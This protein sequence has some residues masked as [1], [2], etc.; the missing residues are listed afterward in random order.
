MMY[1]ITDNE[2]NKLS[3]SSKT[4]FYRIL[5]ELN[6]L[7]QTYDYT[8]SQSSLR[9]CKGDWV[10]CDGICIGCYKRWNEKWTTM[11]TNHYDLRN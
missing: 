10:Y 3:E 1:I 4:D 7:V 2:I 8:T 9:H 11:N 6:P 5:A